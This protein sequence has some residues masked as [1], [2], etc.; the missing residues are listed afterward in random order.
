MSLA[1]E[2]VKELRHPLIPADAGIKALPKCA[3]FQWGKGWFP[4]SAGTNGVAVAALRQFLHMHLRG[5]ERMVVL[6]DLP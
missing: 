6:A 4:A 5:D 2:R 3:D 1:F